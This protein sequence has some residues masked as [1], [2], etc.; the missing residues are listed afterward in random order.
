MS[1]EREM[2]PQ[3]SRDD[4]EHAISAH[5]PASGAAP[6]GN[7]CPNCATSL[8]PKAVV[9]VHCGLD[10]RTGKRL[11]TE[12]GKLELRLGPKF[13]W[14]ERMLLG[15]MLILMFNCFP[16]LLCLF[17]GRSFPWGVLPF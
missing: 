13:S 11:T 16:L 3:S 12:R 7:R 9:C 8:T 1:A 6:P 4:P 15:S 14:R 2:S 17:S 10:L 5:L